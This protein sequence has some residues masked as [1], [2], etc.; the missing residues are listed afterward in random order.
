MSLDL[1]A[2]FQALVT[3][4]EE[5]GHALAGKFRAIFDHYAKLGEAVATEVRP[6]IAKDVADLVHLAHTDTVQGIEQL[7]ADVAE[8]KALLGQVINPAPAPAPAPAEPT[9]QA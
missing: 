6:L 3:K 4:L 1:T 8:L 7:R 2:E 9:A 5:E